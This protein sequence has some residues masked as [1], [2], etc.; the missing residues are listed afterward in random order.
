MFVWIN[1]TGD[2]HSVAAIIIGSVLGYQSSNP[3]QGCLH[4]SH[5]TNIY[6]KGM[7]P[8]ILSPA[9]GK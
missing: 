1:V 5:N 8:A 2:T 6:M 4:F 3:E 7:N 9:M